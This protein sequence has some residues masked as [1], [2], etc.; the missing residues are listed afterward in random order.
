[1]YFEHLKKLQVTVIISHTIFTTYITQKFT[2]SCFR[3]YNEQTLQTITFS[4]INLLLLVFHN[5]NYTTFETSI[6]FLY[7]N[8]RS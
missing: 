2:V 1:M 5:R 4:G 6:R 7:R 3:K 8:F